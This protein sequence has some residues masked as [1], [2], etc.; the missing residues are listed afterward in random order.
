MENVPPVATETKPPIILK[1]SKTESQSPSKLLQ[2]KFKKDK[3]SELKKIMCKLKEPDDTVEKAEEEIEVNEENKI[4]NENDIIEES[5]VKNE[6]EV[7][8]NTCEEKKNEGDEPLEK[9]PEDKLKKEVK[10][11]ETEKMVVENEA[12]CEKVESKTEASIGDKCD[13]ENKEKG[14]ESEKVGNY[15]ET[16]KHLT[17]KIDDSVDSVEVTADNG[18]SSSKNKQDNAV[19]PS[20]KIEKENVSDEGKNESEDK[21]SCENVETEND[22]KGN[23]E[24]NTKKS[25]DDANDPVSGDVS[26]SGENVDEVDGITEPSKDKTEDESENVKVKESSSKADH[27]LPEETSAGSKGISKD[28]VLSS[29]N[30]K[31]IVPSSAESK[32]CI[33]SHVKD[34]E[35]CSKVADVKTKSKEREISEKETDTKK[36]DSKEGVLEEAV[37]QTARENSP[38]RS[39]APT[40]EIT[41]LKSE[42]KSEDTESEIKDMSSAQSKGCDKMSNVSG[43]SIKTRE[44]ETE[45]SIFKDETDSKNVVNMEDK[46]AK[47]APVQDTSDKVS[48]DAGAIKSISQASS[49]VISHMEETHETVDHSEVTADYKTETICKSEQINTSAMKDET[50]EEPHVNDRSTSVEKPDSLNLEDSKT[51]QNNSAIQAEKPEQIK[52]IKEE[53]KPQKDKV[54]VS[55]EVKPQE[56]TSSVQKCR[57]RKSAEITKES[58][59]SSA[60]ED[61]SVDIENKETK[62]RVIKTAIRKTTKC[63]SIDNLTNPEPKSLDK[64]SKET[65]KDASEEDVEKSDFG[66]KKK[67][68]NSVQESLEQV[69]GQEHMAS[70]SDGIQGISKTDKDKTCEDEDKKEENMPD[71]QLDKLHD[72]HD[73]EG[74][75][76]NDNTE[77]EDNEPLEDPVDKT[78]GQYDSAEENTGKVKGLV[79]QSRRSKS[80]A[81]KRQVRSY[82]YLPLKFYTQVLDKDV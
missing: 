55:D 44:T 80:Q 71:D 15:N 36:K 46:K 30:E 56:V 4:K 61:E 5:T 51:N 18:H 20:D 9:A 28:K 31:E 64:L 59:T 81:K 76:D 17:D 50:G 78:E 62:D 70:K 63:D 74:H 23:K 32:D 35:A 48:L 22:V 49:S 12:P 54:E 14:N 43:E 21:E 82:Y 45:N 47:E 13:S 26:D 75:H 66:K 79:A 53:E 67:V 58:H 7:K 77:V 11:K 69:E 41:H 39:S 24:N 52:E 68:E 29:N 2:K 1:V 33:E 65:E 6:N 34:S 37:K 38:E 73:N 40:M 3:G 10:I 42:E 72:V 57:K 60:E 16:N 19:E 25:S 27:V 8:D